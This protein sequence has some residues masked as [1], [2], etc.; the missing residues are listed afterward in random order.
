MNSK[1]RVHAAL[2]RQPTDRVP[3]FMW[4][5]PSTAK[6][7]GRLLE[8]PS[9]YVA[10]AMGELGVGVVRPHHPLDVEVKVAPVLVGGRVLEVKVEVL[11]QVGLVEAEEAP[12]EPPDK[13]SQ[14]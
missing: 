9:G 12:D 7:L 11:P 14:D 3:I 4:F 1:E 8:V 10:E 6:R 5:H 2:K 13:S